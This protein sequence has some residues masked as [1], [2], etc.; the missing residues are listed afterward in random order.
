MSTT[1]NN[2][3]NIFYNI[4]LDDLIDQFTKSNV[5]TPE[6]QEVC[7]GL[8]KPVTGGATNAKET[9]KPRKSPKVTGYNVYMREYRETVKNERPDLS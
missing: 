9:K 5:M 6:L 4:V 3:C 1:V 2:T 7:D 8:K